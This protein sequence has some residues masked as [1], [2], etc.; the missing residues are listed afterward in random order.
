MSLP[1]LVKFWT[2]AW[3]AVM[4]VLD[5]LDLC[6]CRMFLPGLTSS[7]TCKTMPHAG[8]RR[9][10]A[11]LLPAHNAR[12]R[13]RHPEPAAARAAACSD[14]AWQV[15]V[16]PGALISTYYSILYNNNID[17]VTI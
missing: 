9:M 11:R 13:A 14:A 6:L 7:L 1:A 8:K 2:A 5:L 16:G 15:G 3:T 10:P 17:V 4:T 12:A